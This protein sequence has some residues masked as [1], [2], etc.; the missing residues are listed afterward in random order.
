LS[1]SLRRGAD[2]FDNRVYRK[3]VGCIEHELFALSEVAAHLDEALER[4]RIELTDELRHAAPHG[5][6]CS[7]R[8]L[9]ELLR[10]LQQVADHHLVVR[11]RFRML[12]DRGGD[13]FCVRRGR[14]A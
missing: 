12:V 8:I 1:G 14:L 13:R 7:A 9:L 5:F 3:T 6:G 4:L 11:L 10:N 2:D